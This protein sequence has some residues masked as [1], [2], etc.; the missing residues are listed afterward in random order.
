M[1]VTDGKH[2]AD[3]L[4]CRAEQPD[5]KEQK[6]TT[7]PRPYPDWLVKAQ[8]ERRCW[9]DPEVATFLRRGLPV[10]LTGL[11]LCKRLIGRWT[12]DYIAKHHD[13][14][15]V[16]THFVPRTTTQVTR[17]YGDGAG[18]GGI[19][20]MSFGG[21]VEAARRNERL[22]QPTWRYYLQM[23]LMWSHSEMAEGGESEM[24]RERLAQS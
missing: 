3:N 2:I 24:A 13:G 17:F 16:N 14:P 20:S 9:N 23:L 4:H 18:E 10:I 15:P 19:L 7:V 1:Q 12:Y 8:V 11:P 22:I 5:P 21:F 6:S